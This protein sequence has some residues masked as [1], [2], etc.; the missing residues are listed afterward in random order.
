[1]MKRNAGHHDLRDSHTAELIERGLGHGQQLSIT[2]GAKRFGAIGE[3]RVGI[4]NDAGRMLFDVS[5]IVVV[6]RGQKV[7]RSQWPQPSQYTQNRFH[8]WLSSL[9]AA[10]AS[11]SG[12][13]VVAETNGLFTTDDRQ[14]RDWTW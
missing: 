12:I 14:L 9:S 7:G 3:G 2:T 13:E 10:A 8:C 6:D 5:Q 11:K 1:M 4:E